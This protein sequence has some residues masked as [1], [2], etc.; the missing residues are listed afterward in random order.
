MRQLTIISHTEHYK[1]SEGHIVGLGATVTEINQLLEIFD[2]IVHVAVLYED[3][4]PLSALPYCSKRIQFVALPSVGGHGWYEKMEV[5]WHGPRI[6]KIIRKALEESTHFQFR[7]PTGI[8]V[9]VIPYLVLFSS[10]LGWF[11]YAGN[12]KQRQAPWAYGFQRW[13][14]QKQKRPVTINGA[15]D[16]QPKHCLTFKN[17]CLTQDEFNEGMLVRSTKTLSSTGIT[18]CFVGRLE[19]A[20]GLDLFIESLEL[21]PA[22]YRSQIK[23]VHFAGEGVLKETHLKCLT[24][25]GIPYAFH[26]ALGRKE[27]QAIYKQSHFLI[28]PSESEGFPKVI[29]EA[30]NYGCVPI[31]SKVSAIDQYI[32]HGE[33]GMLLNNLSKTALAACLERCLE[34][35]P[36]AFKKLINQPTTFYEAFTYDYYNSRI[37]NL[38]LNAHE[39]EI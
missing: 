16:D 9:Y 38:I 29:S 19:R 12:W 32:T 27:V 5:L 33:Q 28:L 23:M 15:W 7:A 30:L 26:G 25:S 36:V 2:T 24:D 22:L 31:T 13:I 6:I 34:M 10:K 1:T 4:A 18:L 17:P 20:K 35:S 3:R 39:Q 11:K 37:L 14:L 21:L 8:G